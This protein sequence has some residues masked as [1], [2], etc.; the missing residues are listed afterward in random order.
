MRARLT[1][2]RAPKPGSVFSKPGVWLAIVSGVSVVLGW[3]EVGTLVT[4]NG[5]IAVSIVAAVFALWAW[6][7]YRASVSLRR[8]SWIMLSVWGV[9]CSVY[10]VSTPADEVLVADGAT[11]VAWIE[12]R[13]AESGR[14][15]SIVD[16][17]DRLWA[18]GWTRLGRWRAERIGES[19]LE[20]SLGSYEFDCVEFSWSS[21]AREWVVNR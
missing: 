19:G 9:A 14:L 15:P 4:R 20:I 13:E 10:V 6:A 17:Q 21:F 8:L 16:V 1:G 5:A 3:S 12:A 18:L 2:P 11:V 7:D